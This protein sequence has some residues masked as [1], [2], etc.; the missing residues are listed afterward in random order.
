MS[1]IKKSFSTE[2]FVASYPVQ[3]EHDNLRLDQF[4]MTCMP[5]LSR[6]F[7]KSKI[8][9]GEVEISGRKPPHKSSV[10]VHFGETV[11]ITT[12]NDNEIE[13]EFWRG[14]VVPKTQ[15]PKVVFEDKDII[16]INKPPFMITH[17]AGR[18]LFYCATV[19]FE[20]IHKHTIHSIHRLDRETT[21]ILILG[22]N[23]KAAQKVSL[24]F[25][26]DKVRKC[27]FLI[28][29]K[30]ENAVSFPFTAKERMGRKEN[31]I[32]ESM[33]FTYPETAEEGKD[34]ET[35]FELILE[36]DGI[37]LAL[38]F[39][40]TGRQ[41]QIRVHAAEHGYPLLGDKIYNGDPQVFIR[42]KDH[43]ANEDDHEKMQIPRQALHAAALKLPYPTQEMT[44]FIAPLPVDL[45][46]WIEKKL[47][48]THE[49]V[50]K[51]ME[52]KIKKFLT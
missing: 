27:Y 12:W 48:L 43:Q 47:G 34:A 28:A 26:E 45:S 23:P 3:Q 19:F 14:E 36:K 18:N 8:E 9:K 17:P 22:K 20:T 7:L 4:V 15:E 2:K 11:T 41:H 33:I 51:M 37:V 1:E 52:E 44:R 42:F 5:T 50:E 40:V 24:L 38:A 46:Q 49:E 31:V 39:P 29:H 6:Q 32:P 30:N 35:H 16:V 21:G 10:K 25:E 13:E